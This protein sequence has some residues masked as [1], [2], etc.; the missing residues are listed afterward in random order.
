[1]PV[2]EFSATRDLFDSGMAADIFILEKIDLLAFE[3]PVCLLFIHLWM[4]VESL[5][6]SG[7][8]AE[9]WILE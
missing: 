1:M 2:L 9:E 7:L 8:Y 3:I 6:S 4:C 5:I